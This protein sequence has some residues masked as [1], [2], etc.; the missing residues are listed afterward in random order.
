MSTFVIKHDNL[1]ELLEYCMLLVITR[2]LYVSGY[3]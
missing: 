2:L 3:Y 1:N